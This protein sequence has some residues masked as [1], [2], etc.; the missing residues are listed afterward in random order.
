MRS[1]DYYLLP[2]NTST[3]NHLHQMHQLFLFLYKLKYESN[4]NMNKHMNIYIIN[5]TICNVL[6][7]SACNKFTVSCKNMPVLEIAKKCK[8][9]SYTCVKNQ[10]ESSIY[11]KDLPSNCIKIKKS[12]TKK[13]DRIKYLWDGRTDFGVINMEINKF[14]NCNYL[15]EFDYDFSVNCDNFKKILQIASNIQKNISNA[16]IYI[17]NCDGLD[18]VQ[19]S[20]FYSKIS[21]LSISKSIPISM[22]SILEVAL[23]AESKYLWGTGSSK[24][25]LVAKSLR[26][27]KSDWVDLPGLNNKITNGL[28]SVDYL[29]H[30]ILNLKTETVSG[31]LNAVLVSFHISDIY[32][33]R[34]NNFLEGMKNV[35]SVGHTPKLLFAAANTISLHQKCQILEMLERYSLTQQF[36]S[37]LFLN[38]THFQELHT[39]DSKKG[40]PMYKVSEGPN[41]VFYESISIIS[42]MDVSVVLNLEPDVKFMHEFWFDELFEL[43]IRDTFWICGSYYK[44][45]SRLDHDH[46]LH[47]NGVALYNVGDPNFIDFISLQKAFH[48]YHEFVEGNLN[49]D[50]TWSV[51]KKYF[52]TNFPLKHELVTQFRII[53]GN[54]LATNLILNFSPLK[55]MNK[56]TNSIINSYPKAVLL[57]QKDS[58]IYTYISTEEKI[59]KK[60]RRKKTMYLKY[61]VYLVVLLLI[62]SLFTT[63]RRIDYHKLVKYI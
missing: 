18:E 12:L 27:N 54:L 29:L 5:G 58:R 17:S 8:S 59:P 35:S 38:L 45:I 10:T 25:Y 22:I 55:D 43:S 46:S 56:S 31:R 3:Y 44:G 30:M 51:L 37:I 39:T 42:T 61:L 41:G 13:L 2:S 14:H 20:G 21:L 11:N 9:K 63:F 57:H 36:S 26:Q 24:M 62:T 6:D 7:F 19:R 34:I 16:P 1:M 28:S 23:V 33:G 47:L 50:T 52:I 4:A 15:S 60:S 32:N 53:D 49:Y 40:S 48:R